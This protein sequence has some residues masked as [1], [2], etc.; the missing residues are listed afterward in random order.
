MGDSLKRPEWNQRV[1]LRVLAVFVCK[2]ARNICSVT[3]SDPR[4]SDS[5]H[6]VIGIFF[7]ALEFRCEICCVHEYFVS[8]RRG[9]AFSSSEILF[10][11]AVG[12]Y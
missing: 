2:R 10:R 9:S 7:K 5:L 8:G 6:T 11:L 4:V 12:S 1:I 3:F